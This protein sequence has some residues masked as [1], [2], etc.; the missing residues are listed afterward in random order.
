MKKYTKFFVSF[1]ICTAIFLTSI[2]CFAIEIVDKTVF[3]ID[4]EKYDIKVRA[5]Q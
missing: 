3:K 4:L 5:T 1:G 2:S